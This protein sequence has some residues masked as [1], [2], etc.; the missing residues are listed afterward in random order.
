MHHLTVALNKPQ[1]LFFEKH[2]I[3]LKF[4]ENIFIQ[5]IQNQ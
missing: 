2:N 1:K 4:K 5:I 3:I